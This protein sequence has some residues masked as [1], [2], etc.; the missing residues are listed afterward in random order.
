MT[1][2]SLDQAAER[3]L[4][5]G[6]HEAATR[7]HSR[8]VYTGRPV[9]GDLLERLRPV[10][11]AF[12]PFPDARVALVPEPAADVFT[13]IAGSY[14]KVTGAPHL[15]AVIADG[16]SPA[17]RQHAGYAGE[18]AILQAAAMGL[19]TCW[20]GGFF[21]ARAAARIVALGPS[22]RIV[23]VSPL[24]HA[25]GNRSTT[26]RAMVAMARSRTRKP[27][28]TIAPGCGD[29]PAWA[30]AA[31]ECVRIAPSAVNRQPWRLRLADGVLIVARDSAVETPKVAK[32]LDCGIAMLHAQIGALSADV[33]GTWADRDE[34]LDIAAFI[35]DRTAETD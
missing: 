16:S 6:W 21:D 12:R 26:E 17:S 7:R 24:G 22:E 19:D 18:A 23:A 3:A 8:R 35:P 34:G 15:I 25:A 33:P 29:W 9:S 31:A 1:G 14:G 13:G 32:A 2:H 30:R 5:L 11:E 10:C 28:D 20:V 27:L 4:M